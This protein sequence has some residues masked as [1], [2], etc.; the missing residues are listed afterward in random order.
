MAERE[1]DY[2]ALLWSETADLVAL[3]DELDDAEFDHASLCDGWRVRDVI[4]HLVLGH[5]TPM[6]K[7][8]G[9]IARSGFNVPQASRK[10][11][12]R[13][14][15]AHTPTELRD[16]WHEVVDG[17]VRRGISKV[18]STKEMFVDHLI[19]HQDIR[20][21][22][23]RPRTIPAERLTAALD[24]LPTIGGFLKS[25]QRM[26]GITWTADDVEW[27]FGSGPP[28]TGPAEALIMLASGRP[29]ALD[30][31]LGDGLSVIRRRLAA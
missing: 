18:I 16:E 2:D 8:V 3:M 24:T 22:L 23:D 28:V 19:H 21:P 4:S 1:H 5:V 7:M 14:G 10:G 29:A 11:S 17:R 9:L 12:A 13:Y 25:K 6:P 27:A 30:E 26:R 15:S 31:T 20:R